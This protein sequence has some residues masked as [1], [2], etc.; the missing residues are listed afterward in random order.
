MLVIVTLSSSVGGQLSFGEGGKA[1]F[2]A[3]EAN[4]PEVECLL[5]GLGS[6]DV[7]IITG[8]LGM[9]GSEKGCKN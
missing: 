9:G 5:G 3:F 1:G 8:G 4:L 2:G 7:G 6:P